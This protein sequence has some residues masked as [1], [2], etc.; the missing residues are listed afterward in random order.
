[1]DLCTGLTNIGGTG[2]NFNLY[3]RIKINFAVQVFHLALFDYYS[4]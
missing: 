4:R 2:T 1:M 3:L